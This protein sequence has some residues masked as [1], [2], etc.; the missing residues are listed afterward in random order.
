M[1]WW[2]VSPLMLFD[3]SEEF[4]DSEQQCFLF[5]TISTRNLEEE[6]NPNMEVFSFL[7]HNFGELAWQQLFLCPQRL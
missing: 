6:K 1:T 2:T 7:F 5:F 3:H 4:K